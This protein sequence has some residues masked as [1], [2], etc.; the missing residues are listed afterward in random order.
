MSKDEQILFLEETFGVFQESEGKIKEYNVKISTINDEIK[1]L[2]EF[3]DSLKAEKENLI[4]NCKSRAID[5]QNL[6]KEVLVGE[7]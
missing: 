3:R 6:Q 5:L 4:E 7:E 2:R 1:K